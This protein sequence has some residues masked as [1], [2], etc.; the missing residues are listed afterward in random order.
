MLNIPDE[1]KALF[2]ADSV[3][4]N[5]H[6]HFPNNE[7]ADLNNDDIVS[8]SVSFTESICSKDV[9]QFGLSE[10]S[11]IQFECVGV[12]N[13]YGMTIECAI[14]IDVATLG[15]A[16]ISSHQPTG[17][18]TFLEPQ[19]C[20][21]GS[22]D[23]YRVPYG[24]F[25]IESCPRS[26]G[27]MKHRRVSAYSEEKTAGGNI[28]PVL[29]CKEQHKANA[30]LLSADGKLEQNAFLL[31]AGET[32]NITGLTLTESTL[33]WENRYN[34]DSSTYRWMNGGVGYELVAHG[35]QYGY[36]STNNINSLYRLTYEFDDSALAT[37]DEN[38]LAYVANNGGDVDTAKEYINEYIYPRY[39]PLFVRT[40]YV[41]NSQHFML[42]KN[43]DSG[44]F[45]A[46]T[47]QADPSYTTACVFY[48]IEVQ[49]T[50]RVQGQSGQTYHVTPVMSSAVLKEYAQTD[51]D[52]NSFRIGIKPTGTVSASNLN[53][54][55]GGVD[56]YELS[57]GLAEI[58]AQFAHADRAGGQVFTRI[59]KTAPVPMT[60]AEYSELW[61]DEYD[62]ESIG[63]IQYKYYD[64]QEGAE[65][66]MLYEFGAGR[67]SYDMLNN[68]YLLNMFVTAADLGS[69]TVGDYVKNILETYFMP[70]LSD[71]NFTPVELSA[72][73]LPYL[74]AGDYLEIDNADGGT[75]GTYILTRTI[76][77]IQVLTDSIESK[78]GEVMGDGS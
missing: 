68:Y 67:S 27:A 71:I 31:L 35:V 33:T 78:G 42:V 70:Y 40:A 75:V 57:R 10:R 29:S 17:T 45:Y 66:E 19:L 23:M 61:W 38:V 47:P 4:K 72:I 55:V 37:I 50:V 11:Q 15:V 54:F 77:G 1:V 36:A 30:S 60:P 62:V 2:K 52:I 13:I 22:R 12:Q 48:P 21:Y 25:I 9:F 8:E 3:F 59:N 56:V 34:A 58:T 32:Q 28:S 69:G 39:V 14:E 20:Q 51:T 41:Y 65:Q 44:Y 43:S 64:F 49:F 76:N 46:Y 6:V 18:E 74:E 5:F 7:N 53:T 73:G 63:S 16:W 26:Q 24:R